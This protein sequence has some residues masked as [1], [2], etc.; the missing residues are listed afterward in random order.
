MVGLNPRLAEALAAH[1]DTVPRSAELVF[2]HPDGTPI[3]I[4]TYRSYFPRAAEMVGLRGFRFHDLRHMHGTRLAERGA[5][6]AMIKMALGHK[7]LAATLRYIDH[8]PTSFSVRA[9]FLLAESQ[10]LAR[11]DIHVGG[12]PSEAPQQERAVA[13]GG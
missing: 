4:N 3:P 5:P 11:P 7:C 8:A 2:V 6:P 13:K 12:K 10:V 1:L 9:A